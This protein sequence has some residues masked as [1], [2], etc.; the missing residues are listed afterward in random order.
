MKV[1]ISD[2]ASGTEVFSYPDVMVTCDPANRDR[3]FKMAPRPIVEVLLPSPEAL[4]RRKKYL[5][6]Q[7]LPSLQECPIV[8]QEIVP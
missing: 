7:R 3:Y 8:E 6:Y 4:D 1:R 2:A 5:D